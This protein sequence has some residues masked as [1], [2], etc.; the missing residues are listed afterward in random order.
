MKY[1]DCVECGPKHELP[2]AH[3]VGGLGTPKDPWQW[4]CTE[5]GHTWYSNDHDPELEKEG[6]E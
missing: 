6:L 2:Q 3:C 1:I 4:E 5:C